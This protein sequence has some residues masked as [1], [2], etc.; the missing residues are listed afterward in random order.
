[1]GSLATRRLSGWRTALVL[2]RVSN[3]P[4]VWSNVIA[5]SALA[6]GAP[7]HWLITLAIAISLMYVAGM[8]LNDAFD[9]NVDA[10]ERPERP[11]PAGDIPADVVFVV[12]GSL[13]VV[14]MVTLAA[15]NDRVGLAG[16]GLGA[17]ILLYDWHHKKNPLA[18]FIMGVCRA[19]VYVTA[20]LATTAALSATILVPAAALLAYVAGL[21]YSARMESLDRIGTF[22]PL[23][24][25]AAPV[26]VAGADTDFSLA[27]IIAFIALAACAVRVAL[28]LR[29]RG[30]GD[31]SRA[32][33]LLIAAI[34]LNDALFATT[35]DVD[36]AAFACLACFAL[37]LVLQRYVPAS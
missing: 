10:R 19:L 31:V 2:G 35:T 16:A 11:I 9:R 8:F 24:L 32:V 23:P 15:V 26:I 33:A 30:A 29:H 7:M 22:W 21:T 28:L 5:G 17:A 25:L 27:A 3:L 18:P 6:G 14:G 1:M 37:T 12:G 34:S 20:A 4:T 36:Y 13:L